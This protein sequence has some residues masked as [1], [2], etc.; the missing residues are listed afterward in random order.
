MW[1]IFFVSIL[2]LL[3]IFSCGEEKISKETKYLGRYQDETKYF[4][5]YLSKIFK[6]GINS[7]KEYFFIVSGNGC[8]G[9]R[10]TVLNF[11]LSP[12]FK[13]DNFFGI[14]SKPEED[15]VIYLRNMKNVLIDDE[16]IIDRMALQTANPVFLITEKG[17]VIRLIPLS[18]QN[19]DSL[20][21]FVKKY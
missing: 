20:K 7:D 18:T 2:F 21:F 8:V 16:G 1:K 4:N 15:F 3:I 5:G 6:R 13:K 9:C 17:M 14:V 10:K 12:D 19:I 11:I